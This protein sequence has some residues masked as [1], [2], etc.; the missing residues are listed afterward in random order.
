MQRIHA[1][2]LKTKNRRDK[3]KDRGNNAAA[4]NAHRDMTER[5]YGIN[6]LCMTTFHANGP[7]LFQFVARRLHPSQPSDPSQH[8]HPILIHIATPADHCRLIIMRRRYTRMLFAAIRLFAKPG[9]R[10]TRH[11][12]RRPRL[13]RR[14]LRRASR[15][16]RGRR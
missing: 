2:K 12:R 15:R 8:A 14:C 16:C 6:E 13:A 1:R 5:S 11:L 10:C 7:R 3:E 9:R 4:P